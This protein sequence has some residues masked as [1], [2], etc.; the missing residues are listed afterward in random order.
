MRLFS[1]NRRPKELFRIA[2]AVPYSWKLFAG[3]Q[4]FSILRNEE[5]GLPEP[6][7]VLASFC[8]KTDQHQAVESVLRGMVTASRNEPGCLRYDLHRTAGS[9]ELFVL[10]E[11]YRDAAALEAHRATEHYQAFRP[12]ITS[13]L[14]QPVS[15]QV[16]HGLDVAAT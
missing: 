3:I 7:F 6:I 5:E 1:P 13:L 11:A 10:F 14:S 2:R 12:S 8:P 15:V 16:L 9:P 4:S